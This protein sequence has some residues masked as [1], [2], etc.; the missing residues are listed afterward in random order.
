[1]ILGITVYVEGWVAK[2]PLLPFSLFSVPYLKPLIISLL[3]LF[4][5]LGIFL[6][7]GAL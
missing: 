7:Y 2:S 6:L 3:G 4:G 1:M 5:S